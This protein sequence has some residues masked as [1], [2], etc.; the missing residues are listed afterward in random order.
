[1]AERKV[2]MPTWQTVEL[3][4]QCLGPVREHVGDVMVWP[5]DTPSPWKE[6]PTKWRDDLVSLSA[7]GLG[8][9]ETWAAGSDEAEN[10][11]VWAIFE[12]ARA[13]LTGVLGIL[14]SP[15][16]Q[17]GQEGLGP[18]PISSS[19]IRNWIWTVVHA[20]TQ[21]MYRIR[22]KNLLDLEREISEDVLRGFL[23]PA[24][25]VIDV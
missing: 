11:A 13:C 14:T 19:Q 3:V 23:K 2:P 12:G 7:D 25:V 4:S 10:P 22:E 8:R 20:F 5:E 24:E 18:A 17:E 16:L 21:D 1:M 15:Q 6:E 9:L